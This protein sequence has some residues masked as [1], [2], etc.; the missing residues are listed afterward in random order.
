[1]KHNLSLQ[2]DPS[3]KR[4]ESPNRE[5]MVHPMRRAV[6]PGRKVAPPKRKVSAP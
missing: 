1:M 3:T 6:L 2:Q 4:R 5:D